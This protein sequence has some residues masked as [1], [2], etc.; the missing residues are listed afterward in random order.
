MIYGNTDNKPKLTL[1]EQAKQHQLLHPKDTNTRKDG[2]GIHWSNVTDKDKK[3]DQFHKNHIWTFVDANMNKG[4]VQ[5]A[6][7]DLEEEE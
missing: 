1:R 7:N 4:W 5:V 3:L 6:T 2:K